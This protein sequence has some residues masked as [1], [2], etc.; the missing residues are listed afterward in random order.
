[1]SL[2]NCH[3]QLA[4][5]LSSTRC[6][7]HPWLDSYSSWHIVYGLKSIGMDSL[8]CNTLLGD[9]WVGIDRISDLNLEIPKV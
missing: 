4:K 9:S 8:W 7:H 1:M 2:D 6:E 5:I 3:I